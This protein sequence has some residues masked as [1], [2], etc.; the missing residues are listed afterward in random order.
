MS[1][2]KPT[3]GV[4]KSALD[5]ML[6]GLERAI[7]DVGITLNPSIVPTHRGGLQAEWH[8]KGVDLEIEVFEDGQVEYFF[9]GPPDRF[10]VE[11]LKEIIT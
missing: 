10:L 2:P 9:T 5:S 8:R 1:E 6:H 7:D 3:T 11:H 4:A